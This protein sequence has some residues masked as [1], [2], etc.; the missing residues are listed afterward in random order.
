MDCIGYIL[1]YDGPDINAKKPPKAA[2]EL[3]CLPKKQGGLGV[4]NLRTQNKALL[5]KHLH[6]FFN[7]LD[8]PWAKL[9]WEL[10]YND[11]IHYQAPRKRDLSGGEISLIKLLDSFKGMAA[12]N[13]RYGTSCLLW[14]DLWVNHVPKKIFPELFSFANKIT[15][16]SP[17]S[18]GCSWT[19]NPFP[20]TYI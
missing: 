6:K 15:H 14:D 4:L 20:S 7:R 17:S 10:H 16:L 1:I 3:V 13:I 8:I 11:G 12:V 19:I 2:W 9:V 5:L 18:N